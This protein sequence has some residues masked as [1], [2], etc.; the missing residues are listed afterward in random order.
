MATHGHLPSE[1]DIVVI[2]AGFAGVSVAAALTEA[3]V[4]QR[5]GSR[6]RTAARKP[7]LRAQRSDGTPIRDRSSLSQARHSRRRAA[8]CQD[9]CWMSGPPP[10]RRPVPDSRRGH[11]S[12]RMVRPTTGTMPARRA[13]IVVDTTGAWAGCLGHDLLLSR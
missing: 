4:T 13:R 2:G 5:L 8:P 1:V 7:C 11:P 3:G 12:Y 9:C 6:T 10:E